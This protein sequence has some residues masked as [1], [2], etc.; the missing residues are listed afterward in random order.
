MARFAKRRAG[1]GR[2]WGFPQ[3]SILLQPLKMIASE[4]IGESV[5]SFRVECTNK[6]DRS[7][8]EDRIETIGGTK[9]DGTPWRLS[10]SDAISGLERGSW[11]LHVEGPRR[12]MV[13]VV[14]LTRA[15]RKYLKSES[16]EESSDLL[17]ALPPCPAVLMA[18]PH[19]RLPSSERLASSG[20]TRRGQ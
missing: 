6:A 2:L 7:A 3:C 10:Q 12:E 14:I 4:A 18:S 1:V 19:A 11:K 20:R 5:L 8:V 15:G 16:V 9:A 13:S 17:L